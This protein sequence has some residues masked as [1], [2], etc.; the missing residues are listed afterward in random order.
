METEFRNLR[1][2]W[3]AKSTKLGD[4]LD[5]RGESKG[6]GVSRMIP[7]FLDCASELPFTESEKH[8][9]AAGLNMLRLKFK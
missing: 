3:E 4:R 8:G 2:I 5:L 1:E 6:K 9:E 7:R